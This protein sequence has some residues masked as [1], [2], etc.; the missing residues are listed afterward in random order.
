MVGNF[1]DELGKAFVS[2]GEA[3]PDLCVVT[4]DVSKST[5]SILFKERWPE[6]FC[7]V[8]IAEADAVGIAAGIST[9]GSPVIFTAYGVFA[10]EKPF[11]QIRNCVCYQNLNVKIVAT[12]GG[13]SVGE[14]GATHQAIEDIA[15]M[16]AIPNMKVLVA[17]DP[18]EV[19]AALFAAV[20]TPG[21]V[22]LRLGRGVG[23]AIHQNPDEVVYDMGKAEVLQDGADVTL[24]AAGIMVEQSLLAARAL[25]EQGISAAVIN[26][27]SIKPIDEALLKAYASKTGAFVTAEDHNCYGGV[28]GAVCEMLARCHPLPVEQVALRDTFGESGDGEQL[29]RKYGLTAE[30]IFRKAV[31]VIARKGGEDWSNKQRMH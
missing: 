29:L 6:R 13:I 12:H 26:L 8:G 4:A 24:V 20:Q 17:A 31:G 9:F 28:Y 2:A 21:P 16:R 23:E 5:R 15:I 7:S 18:G 1:R 14:D 11:E 3:F 22:Y 19:K 30:E 25:K 27:R 10:T